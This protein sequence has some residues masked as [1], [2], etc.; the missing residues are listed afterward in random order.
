MKRVLAAILL[1]LFAF[2]APAAAQSTPAPTVASVQALLADAGR[3]TQEFQAIMTRMNEPLTNMQPYLNALDGFT[4]GEVSAEDAHAAIDAWRAQGLQTLAEARVSAG[5]LR[6]PPSFS[7]LGPEGLALEG[8]LIGARDNLLPTLLEI[9]RVV[10]AAADMGVAALRDPTKGYDARQRAWYRASAQLVRVDRTRINLAYAG[11]PQGHP[12]RFLMA[13]TLHYYD[14]LTAVPDYA[15]QE[16]DGGGDRVALVR[17]L[18]ENARAMRVELNRSSVATQQTLERARA[19]QAGEAVVLL[20]VMIQTLE[21]YP[22]SIRAYHGLAGGIDRLA[23]S[24]ESGGDISDAWGNQEESD[25]PHLT[26][27]DRLERMRAAMIANN[28]GTL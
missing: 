24:I 15:L 25:L 6:P 11:L 22:D 12:N 19:S 2:A 3:W 28:G 7:S 27:I 5:A 16:L 21:T 20:R 8:A 4:A 18:R 9:E 13:A 26:E 23:D 17:S 10:N 1:G 14:A